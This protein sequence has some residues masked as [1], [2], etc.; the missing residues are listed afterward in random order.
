MREYVHL[1]PQNYCEN[2]VSHNYHNREF[3]QRCES[4][5]LHP[6]T[7]YGVHIRPGQPC[8][9]LSVLS[10]EYSFLRTRWLL[11]PWPEYSAESTQQAVCYANCLAEA[12]LLMALY[13]LDGF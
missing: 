3:V 12:Q 9:P 13:G 2:P 8:A 7:G 1:R 5:G 4:I 11:D 10:I 6:D